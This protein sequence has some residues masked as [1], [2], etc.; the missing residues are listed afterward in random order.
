[1][2]SED[3]RVLAVAG[4]A[5]LCCLP[6]RVLAQSAPPLGNA[7]SFAVLGGS[8]VTNSGPTIV[9]GNLGVSPGNTITG[10]PPGVAKLG[11]TFKNDALAKAAHND[12][13][14][15]YNQAGNGNCA[16]LPSQSPPPGVYCI[17]SP[18]Q[19]TEALTLDAAG[20]HNAVWI[21]QIDGMLTLAPGSCVLAINSAQPGNVFWQV[22]GSV[23]LGEDS[24]FVGN[25]IAHDNITLN[26]HASAFGR[27]LALTGAVTLDSN[28]V[29][30]CSTCNAI[31]LDPL[32][33]P[34]GTVN[35]GYSQTI[36]A[37]GGTRPYTFKVISGTLPPGIDPLTS[38]GLLS[39]TPTA[40]GTFQFTVAATDSQ[41]C[42]GTHDYT[43][44][45]PCQ[46][47][48]VTNPTTTT[49]TSCTEFNQ[50]FTQ[51]CGSSSTTFSTGS[52][53]PLGLKLH[54]T[55]V[56]DGT[57]IQTGRFPITV[58]AV[59]LNK[60]G[61]GATYTLVITC[62]HIVVGNP[63][64]S[65]GTAG[66]PF[67]QTFM[68]SGSLCATAFSIESGVLPTGMTLD[69]SGTL[70]GTPTQTG[71]FPITVK[72]TDRSGCAGIGQRYRLVIGC[73]T[74]IVRNPVNTIGTVGVPF[75]ETFTQRGA[76]GVATFTGGPLPPGAPPFKF[77][78]GL[79]SGTPTQPGTFDITV[80]VTDSNQCTGTSPIYHL[81][82][83]PVP[84][85]LTLSPATLSY[86]T[87]NSPYSETIT[88]SGGI[89]P[90]T[91][92]ASPGIPPP[93]GLTFNTLPGLI[94]GTPT[95]LG[96]FNFC[97]TATDSKG[98]TGMR[99]YTIT[100]IAAAGGPAL[101][102]SGMLVL[103]MLLI[104]S[105]VELVRRLEH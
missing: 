41:G 4:L 69:T 18:F 17:S 43:I 33:L 93:P 7:A 98:C 103:S 36:S 94:S 22:G 38:D 76:I 3:R 84:C 49:G 8:T 51:S 13:G 46:T 83:N 79:L 101:S 88:A 20:N 24:A 63:E 23:T 57:P 68:Q 30:L 67:R 11:D 71:A 99:C 50:K 1:M 87:L 96:T 59:D 21:F 65:T 55:G 15:A 44:V 53:L 64:V 82:I 56:L 89:G 85:V 72:A 75:S 100:V 74:I 12:A 60:S 26:S 61:T 10:F 16:P 66:T 80:T 78:G 73:Q 54:S 62:P 81:V 70:A 27:L 90:Y 95:A 48:T 6:L 91:F 42:S 45:I 2:L 25:L 5:A 97:I 102:V 104:I 47:I 35:A 77:V 40:S 32:L 34:N 52:T 37:N 31:T 58:T 92:I 28:I 14:S 29:T 9:T 105:G 86:A 19:L 39:G